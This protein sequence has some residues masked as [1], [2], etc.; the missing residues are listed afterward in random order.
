MED[1]QLLAVVQDCD[2]YIVAHARFA[3]KFSSGVFNLTKAAKHGN[4]FASVGNCRLDIEP[5]LMMLDN[6][7]L[8]HTGESVDSLLM[9]SALPH[10]QLRQAQT[11]FTDALRDTLVLAELAR[12]IN[13][14]TLH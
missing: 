1:E 2:A 5:T 8:V 6:N 3:K 14:R 7:T 11:E 10:P 4:S 13:R 9:L 12:R